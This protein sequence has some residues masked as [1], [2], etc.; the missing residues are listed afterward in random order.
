MDRGV[1][2][3]I[4]RDL[5]RTILLKA[6]QYAW[7]VQGFGMLRLHLSDSVRLNLWHR[8]FRV[9]NVSMMHTH[10]WDFDSLIVSGQ[11]V[12]VR[13]NRQ[14]L[15]PDDAFAFYSQGVIKPGPGGGL[16]EDRGTVNLIEC[17]P[18][19]Y[20]AGD[21]YHQKH[22]EIHVSHP[23]NGTVTV[24]YRQRIGEDTALVFWPYGTSW[25]SA[26]PRHATLDEVKRFVDAVLERW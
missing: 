16:L 25:V 12:N 14:A 17:Y 21:C 13:Y 3:Y 11:I 4:T 5:V 23:G 1:N 7:T 2:Y 18:E 24:N 22:D 26:E 6:N 9:P 19:Y 10:P 20:R 8:D 15:G